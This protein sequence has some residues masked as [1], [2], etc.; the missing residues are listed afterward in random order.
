MDFAI[1]GNFLDGYFKEQRMN[2]V[3]NLLT[4]FNQEDYDR[5]RRAEGYEDGYSD[6]ERQK[7]VEDAIMLIQ[8]YNIPPETAAKD[9]NAPLNLVLKKLKARI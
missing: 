4:E 9:M 3:G 7:A 8:K 1:K 5:N 6:G 2:I